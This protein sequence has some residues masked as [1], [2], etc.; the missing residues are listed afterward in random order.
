MKTFKEW[1]EELQPTEI[2]AIEDMLSNYWLNDKT[3][4]KESEVFRAILEYEGIIG[5]DD[6]IKSVILKVYKIELS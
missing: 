5:Y 2:Y 3:Q 6:W 1:R 4:I